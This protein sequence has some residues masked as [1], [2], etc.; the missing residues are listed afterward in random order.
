MRPEGKGVDF[1]IVSDRHV[2]RMDLSQHAPGIAECTLIVESS[3]TSS[4]SRKLEAH[5]WLKFSHDNESKQMTHDLRSDLVSSG[6][7]PLLSFVHELEDKERRHR[8]HSPSSGCKSPRD[9]VYRGN[10]ASVRVIRNRAMAR[11]SMALYSL[12]LD[13]P[14]TKIECGRIGASTI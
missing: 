1:P 6:T 9:P 14:L 12:R 3:T 10:R 13:T 4:P 2:E 11:H 5:Y 7:K 8:A